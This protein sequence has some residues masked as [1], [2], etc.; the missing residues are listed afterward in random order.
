ME[1]KSTGSQLTTAFTRSLSATTGQKVLVK[2]IHSTNIWSADTSLDIRYYDNSQSNEFYL[3]YNIT[4][5]QSSAFQVLDGTFIL[6]E[7]DYIEAKA[8]NGADIDLII[9]YLQIT[10]SEG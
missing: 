6:E 9:S 5:P 2:T 8:T 7:G 10:D 3:A 4:V 1:Y